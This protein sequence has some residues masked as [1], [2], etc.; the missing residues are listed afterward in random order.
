VVW[1]LQEVGRKSDG[2]FVFLVVIFVAIFVV[3]F[4]VIFAK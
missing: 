1:K 2:R 3:I 4:V